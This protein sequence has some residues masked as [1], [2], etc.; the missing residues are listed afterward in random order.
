MKLLHFSD[1]TRITFQDVSKGHFSARLQ[2][3]PEQLQ[4]DFKQCT[5]INPSKR[6]VIPVN[7]LYS[8]GEDKGLSMLMKQMFLKSQ[9]DSKTI[10]ARLKSLRRIPIPTPTDG[11][12]FYNSIMM[13]IDVP[14]EYTTELFRKQVAFYAVKYFDAFEDEILASMGE[15]TNYESFVK[16]VYNGYCYA[17]LAEAVIIAQMWNVRIS[18]V[19]ADLPTQ[20]I[21]HDGTSTHIVLVHNG[22]DGMDGHFSGTSKFLKQVKMK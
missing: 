20:H 1:D 19:S 12:C 18:I 4:G 22:R 14:K 21:Y 3:L 9:Q 11:E 2:W 16:N 7:E 8:K 13:Q 6:Q 5:D 17:G 15:D 10:D